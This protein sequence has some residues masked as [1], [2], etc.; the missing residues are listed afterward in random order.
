MKLNNNA[1]ASSGGYG[2]RFDESRHHLFDVNTGTSANYLNSVTIKASNAMLAD[3]LSTA[4]F[5]MSEKQREKIKSIYP[6]IE[7]YTS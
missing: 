1:V 3:A 6:N 7:I 2:T 4:V 5:V